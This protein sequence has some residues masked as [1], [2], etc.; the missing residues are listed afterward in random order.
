MTSY[1][2]IFF[3]CWFM[4]IFCCCCISYILFLVI[5]LSTVLNFT[6]PC[7]NYLISV[8]RS[9]FQDI[10]I[11]LFSM[12]DMT[13]TFKFT[14]ENKQLWYFSKLFIHVLHK[15]SALIYAEQTVLRAFY[16]KN[17]CFNLTLFHYFNNVVVEILHQYSAIFKVSEK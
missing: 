13:F 2:I 4:H 10:V 7:Q 16:E 3:A 11:A 17:P 15:I 5:M 8:C 14:W 12:L 6:L 1:M 9:V